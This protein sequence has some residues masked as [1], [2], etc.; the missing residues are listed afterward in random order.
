MVAVKNDIKLTPGNISR[1]P[2]SLLAIDTVYLS[3]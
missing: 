1:K 2:T 3:S